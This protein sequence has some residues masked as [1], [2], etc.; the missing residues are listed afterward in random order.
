MTELKK[1]LRK[2]PF[3]QPLEDFQLEVVI[4]RGRRM[5]LQTGAVVFRKGD[6]GNCM[7]LILDGRVQI[8]LET[9]EGR[10]AVLRVLEPGE[11]F[12]EMALL[13]GGARSANA[14]ALAPCELFVLERASFLDLLTSSPELL[15]RLLSGLTER[16]RATDE[17][18]LQEEIAKQ[19]LSAETERERHRALAALAALVAGEVAGLIQK[20]IAQAHVLIQSFK[21]FSAGQINES[22]ETLRLPELVNEI[23]ALFSIQARKANLEVEFTHTLVEDHQTWVGYR[24]ALSR[25]LLN[26]LTNVERRAHTGAKPSKVDV[27][28]KF[29]QGAAPSYV[30][31]VRDGGR[32]VSS[33]DPDLVMVQKLVTEALDGTLHV[34]SKAG[35]GATF[36]VTFPQVVPD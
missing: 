21:N 2:V 31:E 22:R 11:F 6:A 16:L 23:L 32:D 5:P 9:K 12:G 10:A 7:Y 25:V 17:R 24:G 13:D 33:R 34:E 4:K 20:N 29:E 19:T 1:G 14:L 30:L 27:T 36:T 8:Y 3:L 28:L 15:S 35:H 26:L 18:Y